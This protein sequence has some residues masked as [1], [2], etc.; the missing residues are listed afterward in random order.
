VLEAA[1]SGRISE[2]RLDESLVRIQALKQRYAIDERPA[3][4]TTIRSASH[5]A[6]AQRAARAGVLAAKIDEKV[7]PV[8]ADQPLIC[9]EFASQQDMG[10][11]DSD[12]ATPFSQLLRQRLPG[13]RSLR[14]D[15]AAISQAEAAQA[16]DLIQ[17][18]ALL[19][20]A[21]RNAH[22]YPEQARLAQ[23][24][25]A[26]ASQTILLCLRN[27]YDASVLVGADAVLCTHG[28]SSPSLQ[29]AVDGLCGDFV[30]AAQAVVPL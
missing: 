15:P 13:L 30:P 10:A 17:Q 24:L 7:V 27:P 23:Q 16:L 22:L 18:Q 5:L 1:Q 11:V 12:A 21:T 26:Q 19:I 25:I 28:D 6:L 4:E 9:I 2:S 3:L 29:A 20:L 14:L 8:Q